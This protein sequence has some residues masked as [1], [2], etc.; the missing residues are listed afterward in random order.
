M[1]WTRCLLDDPSD[2]ASFESTA[3]E[4]RVTHRDE[5]CKSTALAICQDGRVSRPSPRSRSTGVRQLRR[6]D[7]TA[8]I[9]QI[10][11]A[12]LAE[13][14]AAALSLR[15]V[16]RELGMVSSA[17]YRYVANRDEL[18]TLLVVDAYTELADA[19]DTAVSEAAER[20]WSTRILIAANAIRGWARRE[21]ARYAEPPDE[22]DPAG[23]VL[24]EGTGNG[25]ADHRAGH[26]SDPP[27]A[28]ADL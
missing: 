1:S 22:I 20:P 28:R 16:T 25:A 27:T 19:V 3:L 9:L 21:P 14:G 18:L 17:V 12:Q 11:R 10:G 23:G 7:V 5:Q 24:H 8:R 15:A 13:R 4:L 6:D 26:P 2:L